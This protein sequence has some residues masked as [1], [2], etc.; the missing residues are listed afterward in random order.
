M[1][2]VIQFCKGYLCIK[3]WGFSTERF[4]NLCGNHNIL[5]WNIENHGNY[6]TMCITLK[7]FWCL[8]SITAKTGTR[9]A[10]T[11]RC[12]LPF[13]SQK[14]KKRKIFVIGLLGS[15][16]FLFWMESFVLHVEIKGN[17]YITDEMFLDFLAENGIE[18]GIKKN[19]VDIAGLEKAIRNE[20]DIVTWTSV[21]IEGNNLIIQIKENDL[22]Q[23][24]KSEQNTQKEAFYNLI[25]DADGIIT[26]MVTRSG[27]PK[28][29][30]GSKVR[31]GDVLVEG[32][33]PIYQEDTTIKRY[34]YCAA[35]ADVV[36]ESK[37]TVTDKINENYEKKVYTGREK[38]RRFLSV[39]RFYI[40]RPVFDLHYERYDITNETGQLFLF[41]GY[42]M[43]IY[44]G[45]ETTREYIKSDGIYSKEE[46]KEK[47]EYKV[48]KLI[49]T[50]EE[51]GVQII[52][53]NVTINKCNGIW[54]MKA[55]FTI[56]KRADTLQKVIASEKENSI[57][58]EEELTVQ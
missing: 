52:E 57:E 24:K 5:L 56:A 48:Q 55:D 54:S 49:Q 23:N 14:M 42:P 29:S 7:G 39:G 45:S 11:K 2:Q 16:L 47:F 17:Y 38:K 34:Q 26:Y 18:S 12:G 30:V 33:I 4:I 41:D 53:K 21:Q 46:I 37:L 32:S 8:K 1:L 15:F 6:Y 19:Q 9:V 28:V 31:R 44:Y 3:V 25:A 40:R 22:I 35:D 13:F 10:I 43:P 50:L 51:K 58:D 27:I 36:I 20:Y